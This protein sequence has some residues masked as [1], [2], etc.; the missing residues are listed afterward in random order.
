[1]SG[2]FTVGD[3]VVWRALPG[4]VG[5]IVEIRGDAA[6]VRYGKDHIITWLRNLIA[7]SDVR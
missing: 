6:R 5:H 4:V 2:K 7:A 3:D 1:V